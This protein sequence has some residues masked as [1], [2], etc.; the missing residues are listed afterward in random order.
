M[1]PHQGPQRISGSH[2]CC[3]MSWLGCM[4]TGNINAS[5]DITSSPSD[6]AKWQFVSGSY[7]VKITDSC[8][9]PEEHVVPPVAHEQRGAVQMV[10]FGVHLLGRSSV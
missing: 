7:L 9:N 8:P 3:D 2:Y 5:L 10:V 4:K 6:K 1:E